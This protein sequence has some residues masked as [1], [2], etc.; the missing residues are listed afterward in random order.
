MTWNL[1]TA[2]IAAALTIILLA[3]WK[4]GRVVLLESVSH[5]LRK[6]VITID[7]S[8]GINVQAANEPLVTQGE[9]EKLAGV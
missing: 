6:A 9:T 8:G 4:L 3:F 5:P 1:I 7:S 2:G